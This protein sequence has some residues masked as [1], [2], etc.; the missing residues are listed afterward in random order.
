MHGLWMFMVDISNLLPWFITQLKTGGH[1]LIA[2]EF[3]HFKAEIHPIIRRFHPQMMLF[4]QFCLLKKHSTA[5]SGSA[6]RPN[7]RF[8]S[9]RNI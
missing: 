2:A 4:F 6:V 8:L 9:I 7:F 1:H 3:P 5:F